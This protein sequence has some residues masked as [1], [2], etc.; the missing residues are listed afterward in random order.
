MENIDNVK[1]LDASWYMPNQDRDAIAEFKSE[2]LPGAEYFDLDEV[3]DR[4]TDLPH[5][6]PSEHQFAAA[7]DALGITNNDTIVIYDRLGLFS[8]PRAWWT[9]RVFGHK[10][11]AVLDGGMNAWKAIGG[12]IDT[13]KFGDDETHKSSRAAQHAPADAPVRYQAKLDSKQVRSR[14]EI[15]DNV[16]RQSECVVDARPAPRWKGKAPE[17]RP[18]LEMGHIPGSINIPWDSVLQDGRMLPAKELKK[19]FREACVDF[20][21]PMIFSCGSGTTA[22]ILGLALNQMDPSREFSI[23]DGSWSEWGK[24][25]LQNPIATSASIAE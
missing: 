4:N 17:P 22:C 1:I 11:V 7:A 2:R 16:R 18:G 8:S 21:R 25:E 14:E 13:T 10:R 20:Q 23:Y 3:A 9:W 6:L 19:R 24:P 5:M 15:L 12:E